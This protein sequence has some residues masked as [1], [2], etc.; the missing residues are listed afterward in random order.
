MS[1]I[2]EKNAL[3]NSNAGVCNPGIGLLITS[4]N[5]PSVMVGLD[6]TIYSRRC[7][8][9]PRVKPEDDGDGWALKPLRQRGL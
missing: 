6:P 3:E 5:L 4:T 7:R 1:F 2:A 9:D 8:M